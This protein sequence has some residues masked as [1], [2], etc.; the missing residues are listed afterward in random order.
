MDERRKRSE[1]APSINLLS[2]HKHHDTAIGV[3]VNIKF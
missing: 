1:I 3:G 2:D